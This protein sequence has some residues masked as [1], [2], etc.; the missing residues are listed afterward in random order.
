[1]VSFLNDNN[2]TLTS[3]S[4]PLL[5]SYNLTFDI[6]TKISAK[7]EKSHQFFFYNM[8]SPATEGGIKVAWILSCI[9]HDHFDLPCL[10]VC[11]FL[12][13]LFVCQILFCLLVY[14]CVGFSPVCLLQTP[15]T[16]VD[17]SLPNLTCHVYVSV[18]KAL[19]YPPP[20]LPPPCLSPSP[21]PVTK[22]F[23]YFISYLVSRSL[24][25]F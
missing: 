11:H 19:D 15:P 6:C 12:F 21:P 10:S 1:M 22:I 4:S 18:S 3:N 5:Y 17:E 8:I 14:L 25:L 20:C 7:V 23:H 13:Y 2:K 9:S 16:P 24:L